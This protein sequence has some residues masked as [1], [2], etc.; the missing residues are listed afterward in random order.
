VKRFPI[1]NRTIGTKK[2]KQTPKEQ[3]DE[4]KGLNHIKD[5]EEKINFI[6]VVKKSL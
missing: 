6:H 3:E 4:M 2:T 1:A 5:G